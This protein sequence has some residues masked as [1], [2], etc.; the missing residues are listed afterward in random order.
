MDVFVM[1][2]PRT[3]LSAVVTLLFACMIS[4][5]ADDSN[6]K[7]GVSGDFDP[8]DLPT[9]TATEG[10]GI[11]DEWYDYSF[12][13]HTVAPRNVAWV[14]R[15]DEETVYFVR[16]RRYYGDDGG[17]ATPTML[18][19]TWNGDAFDAPQEWKADSSMHDGHLCL[20][21]EDAKTVSCDSNYDILWRTDKRPVP[22]LGFAPSNP[23]FF[24]ERRPGT[25]VYQLIG[26]EPPTTLPIKEESISSM[27]CAVEISFFAEEDQPADTEENTEENENGRDPR[28]DTLPWRVA[29]ALDEEA[30]PLVPLAET[31]DGKSVFQMTP[32]LKLLQWKAEVD[33]ENNAVVIQTRCVDAVSEPAC[34]DPLDMSADEITIS[35]DSAKTWTF[36]SLCDVHDRFKTTPT[37]GPKTPPCAEDD[38]PCVF[39]DQDELSAGGWPDNRNFDVVVQATDSD[40]RVWVAPFQP[41]TIENVTMS[42]DTIVPR[43]LWSIPG[44]EVCD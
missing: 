9:G 43:S 32:Y 13:D 2:S 40:V 25:E 6:G 27:Q 7:Y 34:A 10:W 18:I 38:A 41:I 16:V 4:A 15:Q 35:L 42:E 23:G 17:S 33:V 37:E 36:V 31:M 5:C 19:H 11:G 1:F 12:S 29:S 21:L 24:V 28:C 30:F 3:I 39:H 26:T 44:D 22:E 14:V 8:T 20:T